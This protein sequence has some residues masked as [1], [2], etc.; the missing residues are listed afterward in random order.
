MADSHKFNLH[1]GD[2]GSAIAVRVIPRSSRNE[3][4]EIMEDGLVK[5]RLTAAPIEGKANLALINYL[6]D[7]LSI[8]PSRIEIVAGHTG[9]DKLVTIIGLTA[10][11]VQKSILSH[12]K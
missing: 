8:A 11:E 6:A 9:K 12:I 4:A 2:S 10:E 5:I 3:I 1:D 7:L